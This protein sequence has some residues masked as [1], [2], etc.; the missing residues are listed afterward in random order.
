LKEEIKVKNEEMEGL[1]KE[2]DLNREDLMSA[3]NL[4]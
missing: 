3:R 2:G 1:M 4:I